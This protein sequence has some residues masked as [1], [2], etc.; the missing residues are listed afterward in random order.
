MENETTS[1]SQFELSS[2]ILP[3]AEEEEEKEKDREMKRVVLIK[4]FDL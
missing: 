4:E 1:V 2:C 3:M